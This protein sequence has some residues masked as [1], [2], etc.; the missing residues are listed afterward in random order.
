MPLLP[1]SSSQTLAL[2]RSLDCNMGDGNVFI[3]SYPKS[4]TTWTQ[5]IV[6]HLLN[7][8]NTEYAQAR[9]EGLG[10][11]SDFSPFYEVD[12][13]WKEGRLSDTVQENHRLLKKRV[14]NTHLL[15][16]MLP[17][18]RYDGK[19]KFIYVLRQ[20]QD[21]CYSFYLHLRNQDG[22]G[23]I[24]DMS[25]TE[26][27]E[28][29]LD[30]NMPYGK[31]FSHIQ[32]WL[33][34]SNEY[35]SDLLLLR[36]QD[37]VADLPSQVQRIALF[38]GMKV[39]S[40]EEL[41]SIL[42]KLTFA[43]MSRNSHLYTPRSVKWKE[44]YNFIRKGVVGDSASHWDGLASHLRVKFD[45]EAQTVQKSLQKASHYELFKSLLPKKS[46]E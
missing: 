40:D 30:G 28:K 29:W 13:T 37:M 1:I 19:N 9:S 41:Q 36:Y 23:G 46:E 44:G 12:A 26:F 3:C 8:N 34:T 35:S 11:I 45:Y 22:S 16:S 17:S 2:C 25:F 27:A 24:G 18:R 10:H 43:G 14:F 32:A 20:G 38:L 6:F 33:N 31:W 21:A 15:P 39:L 5:A 4:G 7:M 42:P